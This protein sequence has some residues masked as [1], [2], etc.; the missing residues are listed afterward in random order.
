MQMNKK[1]LLAEIERTRNILE[2]QGVVVLD[3]IRHIPTLCEPFL[4]HNLVLVLNLGGTAKVEYDTEPIDFLKDDIFV[5]MPNHTVNILEVSDNLKAMTVIISKE[6]FELMKHNYPDGYQE[7]LH[8]HWR[9]H[10]HLNESQA[11]DI[12]SLFR[13]L[14]SICWSDNSHKKYLFHYLLESTFMLLQEYRVANGVATREPSPS[15]MIL[16][17]FMDAIMKHYADSREVRY[18]ASIFCLSPK[19]FSA[20]IKHQSGKNASDWISDYVIVQA[21]ALLRYQRHLSI[22]QISQRLGFPDQ[23]AFARYFK[24]N[25]GMSA[26]EFR[27]SRQLL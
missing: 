24:T 1:E 9:A 20:I 11:D 18:Y 4:S 5:L 14:H 7:N 26:R 23:A 25:T 8:Y 13:V 2:E 22:Q 12:L 17:N 21:K 15:E 27:D 6:R 16:A 19:H 10:I 3:K